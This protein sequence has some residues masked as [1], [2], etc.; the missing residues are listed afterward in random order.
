[1]GSLGQIALIFVAFTTGG[2]VGRWSKNPISPTDGA[3]SVSRSKPSTAKEKQDEEETTLDHLSKEI[4]PDIEFENKYKYPPPENT[5]NRLTI[6]PSPTP[7]LSPSFNFCAAA[8]EAA[9]S[10]YQEYKQTDSNDPSHKKAERRLQSTILAL[11]EH[12]PNDNH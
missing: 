4:P 9:I 6:V 5:R 1:M 12:C 7:S 11:M 8:Q 2:I 10:D 3:T